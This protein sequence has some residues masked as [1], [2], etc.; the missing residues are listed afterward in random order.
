M[1]HSIEELYKILGD[2]THI[3]S[4]QAVQFVN[5]PEPSNL[6]R[7]AAYKML[8]RVGTEKPF[9]IFDDLERQSFHYGWMYGEKTWFDSKEERD[10]YRTETANQ[11]KAKKI[12]Q[13]KE[14]IL[15]DIKMLI[16]LED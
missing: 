16:E 3:Y 15:A 9:R 14:E 7:G 13:L 11:A 2:T 8:Y 6:H 4:K 12:R 10:A 5:Q 1:K